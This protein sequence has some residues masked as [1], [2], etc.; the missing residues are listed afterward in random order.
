A[1]AEALVLGASSYGVSIVLYVAAAQQLGA[2]RSQILF[3]TSPF[4]GLALAWTALGEPVERTQVIA[5][6]IVAVAIALMFRGR[7]EHENTRG[8]RA[9]TRAHRHD[10]GHHDHLHAGLAPSKW[11]THEH[12]HQAVTHSHVHHPDLHHRHA[13]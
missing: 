5:A 13:H 9:H 12:T 11:H 7:H 1:T 6:S 4:L 10:D 3:S 8:A 2:A